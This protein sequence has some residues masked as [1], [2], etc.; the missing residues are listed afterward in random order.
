MRMFE[1]E[2]LSELKSDDACYYVKGCYPIK[3]Q[4]EFC[5]GSYIELNAK[6]ELRGRQGTF[7]LRLL[8]G[9]SRKSLSLPG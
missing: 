7:I 9:R 5:L 4:W 2:I 3:I 1:S 8:C 6:I